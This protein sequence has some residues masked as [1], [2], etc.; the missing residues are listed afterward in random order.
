[1]T[2]TSCFIKWWNCMLA[3]GFSVSELAMI[4]YTENDNYILEHCDCANV[5]KKSNT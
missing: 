5:M 3:K 1:M 4:C 2:I